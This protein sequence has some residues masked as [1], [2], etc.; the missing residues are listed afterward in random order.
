[1][2]VPMPPVGIALSSA[3]HMSF[4][5]RPSCEDSPWKHPYRLL[6]CLLSCRV[7]YK[8]VTHRYLFIYLFFNLST[9]QR[10]LRIML[11]YLLSFVLG[12]SVSRRKLDDSNRSTIR[13][14]CFAPA[15][16]LLQYPFLFLDAFFLPC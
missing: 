2:F 13:Q 4:I 9:L 11:S 5:S 12:C 8:M 15:A 14:L 16:H 6:A 3:R 1:M 10:D 7:K